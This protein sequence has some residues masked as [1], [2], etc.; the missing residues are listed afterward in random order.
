MNDFEKRLTRLETIGESLRDGTVS[1]DQAS[2]LFEEGLKLAQSLD[3][4]LQKIEKRVEILVNEPNDDDDETPP[5]LELFPELNTALSGSSPEN[6][7]N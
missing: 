7:E 4:E 3:T 1:L 6:E 2:K 5:T